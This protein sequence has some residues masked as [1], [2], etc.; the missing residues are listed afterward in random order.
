ML[1]M[2]LDRFAVGHEPE[3]MKVICTCEGCGEEVYF[4]DN[5]LDM[6]GDQLHDDVDCIV[7]YVRNK[8]DRILA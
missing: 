2:N 4:G 6:D 7:E 5:R 8:A 1:T 3:E